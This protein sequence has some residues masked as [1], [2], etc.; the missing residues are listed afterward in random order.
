M[1]TEQILLYALIALVL[2]YIV[3]KY[4]QIKSVQ[5]YSAK[6]IADKIKKDRNLVLLDVRTAKERDR[7]KIKGSFH[8]PVY[9]I[10]S[11]NNELKK[12]SGKE[13]V[14][15]CETGSR[16]LSAA[17]KLKKIGFN[18]ANLKGGMLRWNSR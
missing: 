14:C 4:F 15:Y 11:S 12:F 10:N 5:H 6:E 3:R 16:S 18:A 8:I 17:I 1:T 9:E 7:N 13:I 2:F